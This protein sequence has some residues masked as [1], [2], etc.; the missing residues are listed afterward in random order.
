MWFLLEGE[1]KGSGVELVNKQG[2][3]PAF[4]MVLASSCKKPFFPYLSFSF[5]LCEG[6]FVLI[7]LVELG[8]PPFH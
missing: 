5:S 3:L 7:M 1:K 8:N 4:D 6:V 2:H